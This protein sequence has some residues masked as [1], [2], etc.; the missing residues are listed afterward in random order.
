MLFDYLVTGQIMPT[1]P[2]FAVRGPKHVVK[3]GRTPVRTADE[4]R[5]QLDS[6]DVN[7]IAG[8]RDRALIGVMIYS[9][10][11]VAAVVGIKVEDYYQGGKHRWFRLHEKGGTPA[12][13]GRRQCRGAARGAGAPQCRS[14]GGRLPGSGRDRRR[15][16]RPALSQSGS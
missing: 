4:T 7:T 14:L 15:S 8:M 12:P 9:F 11:R 16:H 10:A 3:T 13:A 5:I 6:I 1:Q 2:A